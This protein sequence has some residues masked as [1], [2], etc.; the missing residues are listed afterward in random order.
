MVKIPLICGRCGTCLR[1][2]LIAKGPQYAALFAEPDPRL[3]ARVRVE[4]QAHP[5]RRPLECLNLGKLIARAACA[6]PRRDVRECTAGHGSV[7]AAGECEVCP[8][9]VADGPDQFGPVGRRHLVYHLLPVAGNGVWRRGIDQLRGRWGLFTGTKVIAVLTGD[10]GPFPLDPPDEVRAYLPPGCEVVEVPNHPALREVA[11]WVPL[12]ERVL[13]AAGDEDAIFYAHAK[14]VTRQVDPGNSC[15]WWASLAYS[16]HLDHWPLVADHL[17]RY[18]IT[19][20]FKKVGYGFGGSPSAWHYSGT[21]FW[22]RAGDFR[23]R[24][25]RAVEP[26]WVGTEAWPGI[27]Y[28]PNEA[29]GLF[30]DGVVPRLDLYSPRFWDHVVRPKYTDWLDRYPPIFPWTEPPAL[31]AAVSRYS[32]DPFPVWVCDTDWSGVS[33]ERVPPAADPLWQEPGGGG[34]YENDCEHGKRTTRDPVRMPHAV[35]ERLAWMRS[36]DQVWAWAE[37]TGIAGLIDDPTLHGGGLHVMAGGGWLNTHLD[38][39]RHPVVAGHERRLNLILFLNTEWREEWGG[40]FEVC[41]PDGTVAERIYPAPGRL[42][43]FETSDLSYH[44]V[45]PIAAGAPE[46]VTLAVYYLAPARPS[47]TRVRALFL[48]RRGLR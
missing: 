32:T 23:L 44:G 35:A 3:T 12:W 31:V 15:Q 30:L 28:H 2:R 42:I 39:A 26:T 24:P 41:R 38:Y 5:V 18:P 8:D 1:C 21:F 47:A 9:Y 27:A 16:L 10:V 4:A 29:G 40:A 6:C 19:G 33:G 14:G 22:V 7:T 43:A 17:T 36:A 25:W 45:Q 13:A 11:S 20:A 46:R 34:V 48:P 37:R